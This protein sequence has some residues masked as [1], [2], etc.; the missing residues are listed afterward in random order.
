MGMSVRWE[1]G[2]WHQ[3]TS[4]FKQEEHRNLW[5][6]HKDNKQVMTFLVSSNVQIRSYPAYSYAPKRLRESTLLITSRLV[7][8]R[9]VRFTLHLTLVLPILWCELV[10]NL[11]ELR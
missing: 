11:L 6:H 9:K 3:L 8:R 5:S 4:T 2:S 10:C 7:L 1:T